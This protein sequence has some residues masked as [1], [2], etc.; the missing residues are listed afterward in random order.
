MKLFIQTVFFIFTLLLNSCTEN[1]ELPENTDSSYLESSNTS[2]GKNQQESLQQKLS[3]DY[4]QYNCPPI[5]KELTG[6]I[7]QKG[8][9]TSKSNEL[10]R[11]NVLRLPNT[12]TMACDDGKQ[13]NV[14]EVELNFEAETNIDQ[15]LGSS[16][17]VIGELKKNN[18]NSTLPIKIDVIRIEAR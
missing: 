12:F 5:K 17:I 16:V 6:T 11:A 15:Y 9:P 3:D 7:Y 10:L 2:I 14:T 18:N 13:I 1:K 4:S 8:I